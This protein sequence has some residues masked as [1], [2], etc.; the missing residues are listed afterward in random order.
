MSYIRENGLHLNKALVSVADT[1]LIPGLR[2]RFEAI[3]GIKTLSSGPHYIEVLPD[4]MDKGLAVRTVCETG[5]FEKSQ[6]MAIGDSEN[7]I[8]MFAEV[9]FRV[10]MGNAY[11][12]LKALADVIAPEC[13]KDGAAWAV[14]QLLNAIHT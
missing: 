8:G 7:D 5:G 3:P 13:S 14:E 9:G 10:A 6:V 1:S 12:E 2:R 4:G 11:P